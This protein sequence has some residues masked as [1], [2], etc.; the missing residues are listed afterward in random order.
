M[1]MNNDKIK[2]LAECKQ[3]IIEKR[4]FTNGLRPQTIEEFV[5]DNYV[6]LTDMCSV[7]DEAA[8][9]YASPDNVKKAEPICIDFV[10]SDKTSSATICQNCGCEKFVHFQEHQS[11]EK[12]QPIQQPEPVSGDV[13]NSNFREQIKTIIDDSLGCERFNCKGRG[14]CTNTKGTTY[15]CKAIERQ[16]DLLVKLFQS[17]QQLTIPW[18][19]EDEIK[20]MFPISVE[21]QDSVWQTSKREGA[22]VIQSELQNRVNAVDPE[23]LL[24]WWNGKGDEYR[25]ETLIS[26]AVKDYQI[27]LSEKQK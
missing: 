12:W 10:S 20:E 11:P 23:M 5:F 15:T 8:E 6:S 14:T 9:L 25:N 21:K 27:H 2:T 18:L 16:L 3:F 4:G 26:Q 22:R 19:S 1:S 13:V 17:Q 7:F 24:A